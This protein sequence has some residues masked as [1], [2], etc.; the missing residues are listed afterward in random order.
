M[1]ELNKFQKRIRI[2]G[3]VCGVIPLEM[4]FL[5]DGR[6][7]LLLPLAFTLMFVDIGI[8]IYKQ[9]NKGRKQ[10]SVFDD[11]LNPD[12]KFIGNNLTRDE[13]IKAHALLAAVT[14]GKG[15]SSVEMLKYAERFEDYIRGNDE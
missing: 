14:W 6:G 13:K 2:V 1:N 12:N 15:L 10:M 3:I 11:A 7:L 9:F 8:A 5:G 4:G